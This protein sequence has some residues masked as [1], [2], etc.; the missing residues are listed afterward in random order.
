[1]V[2]YKLADFQQF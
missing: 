1:M 2:N